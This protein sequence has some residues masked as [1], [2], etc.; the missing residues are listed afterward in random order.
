MGRF[1]HEGQFP[2][3]RAFFSD[4][5]KI[6]M[7]Q[8]GRSAGKTEQNLYIAWRYGLTNPGSEI[9]IICPE[10]KQAK[11]IYWM[12]K[13]LQ[14]YGPQRYVKEHRDSELRTVLYNE[15]YIV[16]DGCENYDA[17]RGIKPNLVFYDEFQH[18]TQFF[19]E[20]VMQPNLSSGKVHLVVTGTPPKRV[21][22]YTE[23]RDYH[24]QAIAKGDESRFYVEMHSDVNPSLDKAWLAKKREELIDRGKENVWLRE[25]EGKLVLDTESAIFPY[26]SREHIYPRRL[27]EESLARDKKKLQWYAIFDPGTSTCFAALFI[28]YNPYTAQVYLLDEIYALEKH[29]MTATSVWTKASQI[30]SRWGVEADDWM[31]YYDE[32][33][34]WFANEIRDIYGAA[35]FPTQKMRAVRVDDEGRAGESVLNTLMAK[36]NHFYVCDDCEKFVWEM[37]NYVKNEQGKYPKNH[38]HLVDCLMYFTQN[39]G[40]QANFIPDVAAEELGRERKRIKTIDELYRDVKA[41]NNLTESLDVDYYDTESETENIWRELTD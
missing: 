32:A 25:Y 7:A 30:K 17:A 23:F 21:C 8:C 28:A 35:L 37:D 34:A 9:Y 4:R 11:K 13:R 3:L 12:P 5:K 22:Y 29:E 31:N 18:H 19:D 38:D 24:L 1:P 39:S 27:I 36:A 33:A 26:F 15:S 40:L 41:K 14:Y 10:I 20:E 16:L 2:L 6:I